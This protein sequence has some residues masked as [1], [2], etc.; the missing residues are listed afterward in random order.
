LFADEDKEAAEAL[1]GS[2]V[3]PAQRSPSAQRKASRKRTE[4][5]QPVHSFRGLLENLATIVRS[6]MR[7]ASP[8]GRPVEFPLVT[9]PTPLQ[10]QALELLGVPL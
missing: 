10:R 6:T 3:A 1:R 4:V 8:S 2:V 9:E 5:G 7:T